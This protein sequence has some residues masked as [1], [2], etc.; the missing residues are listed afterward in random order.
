[1]SCNSL[2]RRMHINIS[3]CIYSQGENAHIRACQS[4]LPV[5]RIFPE[6]LRSIEMTR[7]MSDQQGVPSGWKDRPRRTGILV[8]L[9][10]TLRN[11]SFRIPKLN[12]PVLGSRD[13][14]LTI[15]RDGNRENIVLET[16]WLSIDL[17]RK[18]QT[19]NDS[20]HVNV[21]C[22]RQSSWCRCYLF[23]LRPFH[24]QHQ[25]RLWRYCRWDQT[26]RWLRWDR[27][28]L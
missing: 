6:G 13:D 16:R 4:P 14:P 10:H 15:V 1:M 12:T 24:L 25:H 17:A 18:A 2:R 8:A 3:S 19:A 27:L 20:R 5:A 11:R 22:D 7:K 21:P 23:H 28:C 26:R 9:K